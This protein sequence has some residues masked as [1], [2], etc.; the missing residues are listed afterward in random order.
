MEHK[1]TK[2]IE[3]ARLVLRPFRVEDAADMFRNWAADPE[4]TRH[5][6]WQP[7]AGVEV[8][9]AYLTQLDAGYADPRQYEWGLE[10]KALGQVVGAL[11]VVRMDDKTDAMELG[12][13]LGRSWWGLGLMPEAVRGI[14]PYLFREVGV[15]RVAARHAAENPK[16]GRVM[17]KAGMTYEGT[18]RQSGRSNSG[19]EDMRVYSILA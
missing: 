16:S 11:S 15:N 18:L 6:T 9:Q 1:G 13:C 12:Y 19:L 14:L 17:Q 10:L 8:S 3:T 4:V 2:T 7:H 5:L